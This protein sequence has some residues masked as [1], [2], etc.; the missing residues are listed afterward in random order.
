[1]IKKLL[2]VLLAAFVII[3]FFRP[4][5]N[6]SE[7]ETYAMVKKYEIPEAVHAIL[8]TSCIDCHSNTTTYPWYAKVQ[9]VAWWLDGHVKDG[10]RHFNF[11]EFTN[12]RIAIQN[13]KFEE[14]VEMVEDHEMP[15]PSYTYLGLHSEAKLSDD[16]RIVLTDWAK[17]QMKLLKEQYPAD[18]LV[19]RRR[20]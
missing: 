9:P 6:N 14:L 10:K 11:S 1:M 19:L 13:H 3:Q 16:Q 4:T 15:L 18:S 2:L 7:D 17:A 20:R 8:K 12:R 5:L